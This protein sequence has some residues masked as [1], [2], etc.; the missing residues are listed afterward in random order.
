MAHRIVPMRP[1]HEPTL[2]IIHSGDATPAFPRWGR[3]CGRWSRLPTALQRSVVSC[4]TPRALQGGA[5]TVHNSASLR[6][7]FIIRIVFV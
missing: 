3:P 2:L 6:L 7:F 5:S 1:A 4:M